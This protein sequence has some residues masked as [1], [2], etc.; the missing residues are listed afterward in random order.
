[1][2]LIINQVPL[3]TMLFFS[4]FTYSI[5]SFWHAVHFHASSLTCVT[6]EHGSK[7][8]LFCFL[9]FET[10]VGGKI[11]CFNPLFCW[12]HCKYDCGYNYNWCSIWRVDEWQAREKE[13][14]FGAWCCILSLCFGYGCC[15]CSIGDHYGK[16]FSWFGSWNGIHD[17]PS[18]HLWSFPNQDQRCSSKYQCFMNLWVFVMIHNTFCS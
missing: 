18:I 3:K 7:L 6:R 12:N 9:P 14:Y 2:I 4:S 10:N 17:C 11:D 8:S 5:L 13:I 16:S 1:M 15:P